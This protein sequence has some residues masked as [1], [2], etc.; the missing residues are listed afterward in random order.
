MRAP[1]LKSLARDR[2]LRNYSQMGKTE[3]I[4]LLQNN[5]TPEDLMAP[6][7][8][9]RS[10]PPP[11]QRCTRAPE[12]PGLCPQCKFYDNGSCRIHSISDG[13]KEIVTNERYVVMPWKVVNRHGKN[14]KNAKNV[15]LEEAVHEIISYKESVDKEH[16]RREIERTEIEAKFKKYYKAHMKAEMERLKNWVSWYEVKLNEIREALIDSRLRKLKRLYQISEKNKNCGVTIT[17]A[18]VINPVNYPVYPQ[19]LKL[20]EYKSPTDEENPF[21]DL[22]SLGSSPVHKTYYQLDYFKKV[23]RAYRGLDEDAAKFVKKVKAFIGDEEPLELERVRQAMAKVKCPRKLDIS[24]F[25]QLTR[26]LL[27]EDLNYDDERLLI[28]FYDTFSNESIKLLG[29]MVR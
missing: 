26:K 9:T 6:T 21:W 19:E 10:P 14:C 11:M 29:K 20:P 4:A 27:H 18:G 23:A 17:S 15:T 3:L 12:G 13:D 5:G 28:H 7:P 16:E 25:Y 22:P 1:E 8:C 24:V 2:G